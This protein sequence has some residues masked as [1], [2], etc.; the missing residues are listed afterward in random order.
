MHLQAID[1]MRIL[2]GCITT[3]NSKAKKNR[4]KMWNSYHIHVSLK[5]TSKNGNHGWWS[6]REQYYVHPVHWSPDHEGT[7]TGK[8][9][10]L[11][12]R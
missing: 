6:S 8:I 7:T 4:E 11:R 3:S 10:Y 12:K 9:S 1:I 5:S 2:D